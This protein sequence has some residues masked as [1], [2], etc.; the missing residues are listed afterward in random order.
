MARICRFYHAV[1]IDMDKCSQGHYVCATLECQVRGCKYSTRPLSSSDI[2][3]A[4]EVMKLHVRGAHPELK[5][6]QAERDN[7][8]DLEAADAK[9]TKEIDPNEDE[10]CPK[11]FKIL[12]NKKNVKRHIKTQHLGIGRHKCTDCDETFASKAAVDYHMKKCH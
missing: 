3:P 1:A 11:C 8:N 4:I 2:K 9:K 7:I 12:F 5:N 6:I 10:T